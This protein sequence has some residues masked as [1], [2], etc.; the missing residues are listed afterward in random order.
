MLLDMVTGGR[1]SASELLN[2]DGSAGFQINAGLRIRGGWSRHPNY[3]KHAFRLFFN[4]I[5]GASKLDYPLFGDEG[6]SKFDKIDLRCDQNY[7]WANA[8][9]ESA[10][11]TGAREVFSRDTHKEIWEIHIREVIIIIYI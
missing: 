1:E 3:P 7:S 2:P 11:N 9:W 5:Y 6:T 8:G 4:S 10:H